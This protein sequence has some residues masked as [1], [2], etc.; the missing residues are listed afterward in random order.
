MTGRVSKTLYGCDCAHVGEAIA[1]HAAAHAIRA[2]GR[3]VMAAILPQTGLRFG[4]IGDMVSSREDHEH[5][6]E[7]NPIPATPAILAK[8]RP[9]S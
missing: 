8:G 5:A 4:L 6:K 3:A 2:R 7:V 9:E 1:R